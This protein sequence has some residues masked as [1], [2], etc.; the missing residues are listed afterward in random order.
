MNLGDV[1][2]QV[3]IPHEIVQYWGWF[4]AFGTGVLILG[5]C[6]RRAF[7]G[8]YSRLDAVLW[9]LVGTSLRH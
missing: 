6:R 4:L 9:V 3:Q 7:G 1:Q 8:R 2:V 5:I